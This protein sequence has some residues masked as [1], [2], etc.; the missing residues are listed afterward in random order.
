MSNNKAFCLIAVFCLTLLIPSCGERGHS[1]EKD[2]D[3][4]ER[5]AANARAKHT[6]GR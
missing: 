6:A 2:E 5:P 3:E 4:D 1:R